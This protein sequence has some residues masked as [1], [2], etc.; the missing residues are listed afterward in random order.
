MA[1]CEV[2]SRRTR[3]TPQVQRNGL[4]R[5]RCGDARCSMINGCAFLDIVPRKCPSIYHCLHGCSL[6]HR[7]GAVSMYVIRNH[8]NNRSSPICS[9]VLDRRAVL[10]GGLLLAGAVAATNIA[11]AAGRTRLAAPVDIVPEPTQVPAPESFIDVK[12][13]RLW[14]WDTGGKGEAVVL[15]HP[16]T[17]SGA[18]W[19]YQQPV[20]SAAGYRVIGYSR[21]NHYRSERTAGEG[22]APAGPPSSDL[23][24]LQ[25]LRT[26]LKL[27]NFYL[28]GSAAGAMLAAQYAVNFPETLLSVVLASSI[29]GIQDEEFQQLLAQVSPPTFN[30]MPADFR[31]L[32]PSYRVANPQG[33]ARWLE[34]EKQSRSVAFAQMPPMGAPRSAP[35]GAVP[36][37]KAVTYASLNDMSLVVPTLILTAD[38]DLYMPPALLNIVASKASSSEASIIANAGHAAFWEQPQAF[39]RVVLQFLKRHHR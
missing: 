11:A 22:A 2:P 34:I 15:L 17:G 14:Y 16:G 3:A 30:S 39:N 35:I 13:A 12:N 33:V 31:E 18:S 32:G 1:N 37:V 38:A 25:Q 28:V 19:S 5:P 20:F 9:P 23:E 6:S 26:Q 10:G 27:E 24:D 8:M 21:R 36:G 4:L 29:L 7:A